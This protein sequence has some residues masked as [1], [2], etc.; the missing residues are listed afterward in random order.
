M[1]AVQKQKL[2]EFLDLAHDFLGNGYKRTDKIYNF[3]DDDPF[4]VEDTIAI[5]ADEIK[6]CKNCSLGETRTNT[7]PGEGVLNPLVMVI[8]EGPGMDEDRKGRPFV[9]KAGQLLDKMLSSIGLSRGANAFIANV[10]KCRP[11][12]NRDPYPE[13]TAACGH[14]LFRQILLLKP[15]F[16]LVAGKVA[17]NTLL[18]TA[19]PVGF[20][21]G[22]FTNF[23]LGEHSFPLIVTYHPAALLRNENL[24]RPSWEDLKLLRARIES[25]MTD[26]GGS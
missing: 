8:G 19:E 26:S 7:V 18:K 1:E 21:R 24:K 16:I 9:G 10:V 14:F 5:I 11:P 6:A 17:A 13:E 3:N 2:A 22:K 15:K 20:L 23:V 12:K 25:E 4:P